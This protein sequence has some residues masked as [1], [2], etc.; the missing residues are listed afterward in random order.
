[1]R[2]VVD[3]AHNIGL[4]VVAEGVEDQAA[5]NLLAAMGCGIAQG[6][7]LSR[8]LPAE[9]FMHWLDATTPTL[10]LNAVSGSL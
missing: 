2:S 7:Y 1:M 6:Y 9:T 3:L 5:W 10:G 8:P 4:R